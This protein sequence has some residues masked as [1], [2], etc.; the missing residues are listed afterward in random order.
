LKS[1]SEVLV[2]LLEPISFHL[3]NSL[4]NSAQLKQEGKLLI[5]DWLFHE[6]NF[7]NFI[8]KDLSNGQRMIKTKTFIVYRKAKKTDKQRQK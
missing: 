8:S 6:D 5:L 1:A 7:L 4:L 2:E 3:L